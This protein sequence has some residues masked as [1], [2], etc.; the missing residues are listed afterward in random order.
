MA[1]LLNIIKPPTPKYVDRRYE[2]GQDKYFEA[3]A[4]SST[5][6]VGNLSYFTQE[7]QILDVFGRVGPIKRVIMGLDKIRKVPCGFAFVNYYNKQDAENSIR[8]L[9]G[10]M[11]DNR[12][13][14]VDVDPG[15]VDGRQYGRGNS[16]GQVRDEFREYYDVGRG[17]FG[18]EMKKRASEQ[19]IGKGA[20]GEKFGGGDSSKHKVEGDWE[21][22]NFRGK[23]RRREGGRSNSYHH[24]QD[25]GGERGE[26]GAGE[27]PFKY[28]RTD[29]QPR[30]GGP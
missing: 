20:P 28:R 8:F 22:N 4:S 2:G 6:Y 23:P 25:T 17:G 5:V 14:R 15:F 1:K 11:V 18:V 3:L 19:G 9:N 13:I 10:S 30:T 26:E 27:R 7:T 24:Q 12:P 21:R 16:G 29:W